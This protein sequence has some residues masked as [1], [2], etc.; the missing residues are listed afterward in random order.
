MGIISYK[1]TVSKHGKKRE[2]PCSSCGSVDLAALGS[3]A[4]IADLQKQILDSLGELR[5]SE[6]QG[7]AIPA[8]HQ[9]FASFTSIRYVVAV[10]SQCNTV[11]WLQW[12]YERS[13]LVHWH[14][15]GMCSRPS[16]ALPDHAFICLLLVTHPTHVLQ[17]AVQ[18]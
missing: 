17:A 9:T 12:E 3:S 16:L 8:V 5:D 18:Q 15:C 11:T 13:N 7:K 14:V 2:E 1:L 6:V 10:L 4:T